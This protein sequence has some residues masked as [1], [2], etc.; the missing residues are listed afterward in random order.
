M[1]A[2]G[3]LVADG[4]VAVVDTTA[5][6]YIPAAAA[7]TLAAAWPTAAVA[8]FTDNQTNR[9]ILIQK[10]TKRTKKTR[11]RISPFPSFPSV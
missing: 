5:V 3:T 10:Q 11:T 9:K 8:G 2:E 6:E 7:E 1:V 4:M